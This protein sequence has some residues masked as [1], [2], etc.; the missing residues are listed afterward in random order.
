MLGL[1]SQKGPGETNLCKE[2]LK[3]FPLSRGVFAPIT[4]VREEVSGRDTTEF[5][6]PVANLHD[7]TCLT[8]GVVPVANGLAS[9][10]GSPSRT[11]S[12]VGS[13]TR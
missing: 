7:G 1:T 4:R 2:T 8:P 6:D 10:V 3:S 12:I 13:S 9:F 5:E 11:G